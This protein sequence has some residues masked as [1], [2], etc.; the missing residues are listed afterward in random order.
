MS[1][2]KIKRPARIRNGWVGRI[3]EIQR[4]ELRGCRGKVIA[5]SRR[6][7]L[8]VELLMPY[9]DYKCGSLVSVMPHEVHV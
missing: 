7:A 4:P 8:T 6:Q 2:T 9:G 3:V 1:D 5:Q